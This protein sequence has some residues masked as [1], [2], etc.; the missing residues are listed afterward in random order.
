MSM[1]R[2]NGQNG[3]HFY[4]N[5]TQ[6]VKIDLNFVVDSANGNGLGIRSLKSNGYVDNVFMHTTAT[7]G[8]GNNGLTNPNPH[9][10]YAVIQFKNNFNK[11]LGGF[12][13]FVSPLGSSVTT[14]VNAPDAHVITS[15]GTATLA[16]WQAV[17]FPKGFTPAVGAA[18][19]A[20]ANATIGG[21]ATVAVPSAS[22]VLSVEVCGDANQ[23]IANSQISQNGGAQIIVQFL[24]ASDNTAN[25]TDGSVCGMSFF[26]DASSVTIDGL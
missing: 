18:F 4:S 21:G 7:P 5:I 13:G 15:L 11:Y 22:G 6:P 8:K 2:G 17:G 12:T 14:I 16:Q 3:G 25:P 23:T 24:N 10:G 26:F 19:I 20:T 1:P 9:V